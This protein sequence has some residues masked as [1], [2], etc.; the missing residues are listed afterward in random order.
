MEDFINKAKILLETLPYIKEFYNQIMVIKIGGE[1]MI[2]EVIKKNIGLDL[3][4][5]RY[6]G[7]KPV[8]VH[9]GGKQ[10]TELMHKLNKKSIFIDGLRVT[11]K[12]TMNITEMVLTGMI[13]K[14]LV[15]IINQEG[16]NAVGIS[17]RDAN[18]IVAEKLKSKNKTDYG[19]VGK[20]VKVNPEIILSLIDNNF[21]PVISPVGTSIKGEAYNINADTAASAIASALKAAKLLILTDVRGIYREVNNE[22]SFIPTIKREEIKK[23]IDKKIITGGMLPKVEACIKALEKGVKKTHI[24]D[25]RIPH[26]LILEIFTEAGVGTEIV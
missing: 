5:M 4:L 26:S 6:V 15:G 3:V 22:N 14:E 7:I 23:L 17:G 21:I 11:D 13:N 24:I 12:E 16:G 20:I 9:G 2:S 19:Y 1:P 10:I 18:L 8:V 25:G